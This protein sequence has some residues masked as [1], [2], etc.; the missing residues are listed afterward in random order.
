MAQAE[1]RERM[2]A[3]AD[4]HPGG[5]EARG[6]LMK[7]EGEEQQECGRQS[8]KRREATFVEKSPLRNNREEITNLH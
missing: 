2:V 3:S 1:H 6:R 5:E 7:Q 4:K 8:M